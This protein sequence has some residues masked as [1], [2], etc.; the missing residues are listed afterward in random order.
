M[1]V[2][3][4]LTAFRSPLELRWTETSAAQLK[5]VLPLS[6]LAKYN[7][8]KHNRVK[9]QKKVYYKLPQDVLLKRTGKLPELLLKIVSSWGRLGADLESHPGWCCHFVAGWRW[10]LWWQWWWEEGHEVL[11][12]GVRRQQRGKEWLEE[13]GLVKAWTPEPGRLCGC[14]RGCRRSCCDPTGCW[15]RFLSPAG[16]GKC[17]G[18]T[19]CCSAPLPRWGAWMYRE[20]G[21]EEEPFCRWLQ[22]RG[23]KKI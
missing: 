15:P 16:Q 1:S 14:Y 11:E 18:P 13:Q 21:L 20:V 4:R 6:T 12:Q 9:I 19:R 3:W 7:P 8:P 5:V 17:L 22:N 2:H 23:E 10:W